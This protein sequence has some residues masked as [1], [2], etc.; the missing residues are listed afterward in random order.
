MAERGSLGKWAL[1]NCKE[2]AEAV[3]NLTQGDVR[4]VPHLD[5]LK[6]RVEECLEDKN[7][8]PDEAGRALGNLKTLKPPR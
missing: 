5:S 6:A 7:L 3:G 4:H 8:T 2:L 1:L